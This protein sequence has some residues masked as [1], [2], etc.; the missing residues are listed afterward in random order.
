MVAY[1]GW[2]EARQSLSSLFSNSFFIGDTMEHNKLCSLWGDPKATYVCQIA[3][4]L[5]HFLMNLALQ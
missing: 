1:I 3:I 2:V 5:V 4:V